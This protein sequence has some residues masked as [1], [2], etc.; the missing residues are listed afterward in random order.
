MQ[1]RILSHSDESLRLIISAFVT[2]IRSLAEGAD[3]TWANN[4]FLI[5]F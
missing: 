5:T 3:K 2:E 1:A 4:L